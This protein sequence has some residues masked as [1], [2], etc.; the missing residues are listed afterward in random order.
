MAGFRS[1]GKLDLDHLHL[2]LGGFF[3]EHIRIELEGRALSPLQLP[4]SLFFINFLPLKIIIEREDETF[5][6]I[7]AGRVP[8][9]GKALNFSSMR[10][11]KI[12]IDLQVQLRILLYRRLL[13]LRNQN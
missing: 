13:L 11:L 6:Q 7:F 10:T 3:P 8:V 4:L 9:S 1:L 5:G 2:F 12:L